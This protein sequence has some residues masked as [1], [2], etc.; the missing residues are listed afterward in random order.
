MCPVPRRLPVLL[1]IASIVALALA[2]GAQAALSVTPTRTFGMSSL[3][4]LAPD[5]T[6]WTTPAGSSS[7]ASFSHY[8][9]EGNNLGDGFAVGRPS[10]FPLGIG[11]Y[12]NRVYATV[13]GDPFSQ[14]LISYQA[15][16]GDPGHDLVADDEATSRRIGGNQAMLRVFPDGSGALALGQEDKVGTFNAAD[17]TKA[18]PFYPQGFHGAGINKNFVAEPPF[19]LES[20]NLGLGGVPTFGEPEACGRERGHAG[21]N[22]A[23]G[24]DYPEDVA[25]GLGGLYI[26]EGNEIS[27]YNTVAGPGAQL[28]LRFGVGPGSAAGQLS[29]PQ[30][31]VRQPGTGNLYV[32]E[33]GNR[34]ISV[35]DAGGHYIASFGYGVLTGTDQMEVCGLEIGTCQA[36]VSYLA[37]SRSFFSRLDFAPNGDLYAYMPLLGQIQVFAVGGGPAGGGGSTASGGGSGAAPSAPAT[38]AKEE[39]KVRIKAKPLQVVKGKKTKLTAIVNPPATCRQRL[40]LFQLKDERSWQNLGKALKPDKGCTASK[41]VKVSAK[42]V[43]R[44]VLIAGSN[45]ATLGYSPNLTV[46]LK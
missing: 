2:G 10:Y 19:A 38:P 14:R 9:D 11:F 46:K 42:S 16:G 20:C 17:L 4:G 8:D 32:S 22:A 23:D 13:S 6:I 12:A 27:H 45:H 3:Y 30:S 1:A 35:F 44:A 31:I 24:V 15:A 40:V 36:G 7:T 21:V 26:A 28:D 25:L 18:H 29:G 5:G 34:R 37:D 39:D 33:A 41:L 43:F